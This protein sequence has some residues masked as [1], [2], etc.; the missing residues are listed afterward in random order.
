MRKKRPLCP[1]CARPA[2]A[3]S[4]PFCSVRCKD[5]DLRRWLAGAYRIPGEPVDAAADE[6]DT[7]GSG[8]R[9]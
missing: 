4:A 2:A 7:E 5:D 1:M 9:A 8:G 3:D 6:D